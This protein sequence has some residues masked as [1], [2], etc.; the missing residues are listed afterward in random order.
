MAAALAAGSAALKGRVD[1]AKLKDYVKHA[2]NIFKLADAS[3][4]DATYN[5]SNASGFYRSSHFYDELFYASNWLY[6]ATGDSSYLDK[7]K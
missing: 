7:A 1:D 2:E 6:I 3:K 5:D 4:S